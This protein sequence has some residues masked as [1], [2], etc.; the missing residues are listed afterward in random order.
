[1]PMCVSTS[2]ARTK[3]SLRPWGATSFLHIVIF[4]QL[5]IYPCPFR[6]HRLAAPAVEAAEEA[7]QQYSTSKK[8]TSQGPA[9]LLDLKQEGTKKRNRAHCTAPGEACRCGST[10]NGTLQQHP[11]ARWQASSNA[12]A[13]LQNINMQL[14][15]YQY[16]ES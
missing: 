13:A 9:R 15:L 3:R 2:Q 7:P 5:V 14:C 8:R 16:L 1:M 11:A 4:P 10:S 6:L 12:Q